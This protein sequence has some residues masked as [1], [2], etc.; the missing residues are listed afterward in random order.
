MKQTSLGLTSEEE[1]RAAR[2]AVEDAIE[3][4]LS[5][6]ILSHRYVRWILAC[7]GTRSGAAEQMG[8]DRR[9]IQRWLK[10]PEPKEG[11]KTRVRRSS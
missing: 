2:R 10:R 9:T 7:E 3:R 4:R 5:L 6:A 1:I 8:V 11:E